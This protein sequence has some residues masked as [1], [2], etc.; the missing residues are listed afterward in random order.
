MYLTEGKERET[1]S[2]HRLITSRDNK[3]IY[4]KSTLNPDNKTQRKG[5]AEVYTRRLFVSADMEGKGLKI[6]T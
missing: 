6:V 4:K 2:V 5:K 1:S 3:T